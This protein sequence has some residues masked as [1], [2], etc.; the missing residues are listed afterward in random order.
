VGES[1]AFLW[2]FHNHCATTIWSQNASGASSQAAVVLVLRTLSGAPLVVKASLTPAL[3][4]NVYQSGSEP[5]NG[6]NTGNCGK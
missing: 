4:P 6:C 1:N 2:V 3:S 5:L